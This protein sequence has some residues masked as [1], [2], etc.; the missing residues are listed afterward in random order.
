MRL[1]KNKSYKSNLDK[2]LCEFNT[3]LLHSDLLLKLNETS[4]L[5]N[6]DLK[7]FNSLWNHLIEL[8]HFEDKLGFKINHIKTQKKIESLYKVSTNAINYTFS[9]ITLNWR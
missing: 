1:K 3:S 5:N 6:E 7:K 9:C 2:A 8:Y 4:Y